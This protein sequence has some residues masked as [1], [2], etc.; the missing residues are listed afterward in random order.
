MNRT[1]CSRL[2]RLEARIIPSL[3]PLVI[4]VDAVAPHYA[5]A[6]GERIVRDELQRGALVIV[7]RE[8]ITTDRTDHGT[9]LA[10]LSGA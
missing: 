4:V 5:L 9:K 10:G 7:V 8:R 6:P 1:L 3:V 2:Q